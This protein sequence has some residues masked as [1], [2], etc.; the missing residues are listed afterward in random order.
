MGGCEDKNLRQNRRPLGANSLGK[1]TR[2]M[3]GREAEMAAASRRR[4]M[5]EANTS[6]SSSENPR[7]LKG[8]HHSSVYP[9]KFKRQ[10]LNFTQGPSEAPDLLIESSLVE[11]LRHTCTASHSPRAL[12]FHA[13]GTHE[14][15]S[16]QH[17]VASNNCML[18]HPWTS[19]PLILCAKLWCR[20]VPALTQGV[21]AS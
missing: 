20:R 8:D 10:Q 2:R 4:G 12:S 5:L 17:S 18:F 16:L 15:I 9:Q 7:L 14:M 3:L 11:Q 21:R 1:G 13:F 19:T 6:M